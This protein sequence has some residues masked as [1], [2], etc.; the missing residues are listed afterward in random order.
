MSYFK[1]KSAAFYLMVAAAILGIV[2]ISFYRTAYGVE[3]HV[4]TFVWIG[5]ILTVAMAALAALPSRPRVLNL[6]ATVVAIVFG[7]A[8]IQSVTAQL[9]PLGFWIAGLYTYA[10]VKGY[11]FFAVLILIA[12]ILDLIASFMDLHK[13]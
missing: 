7:W 5:V 13:N 12:I 6:C 8:L 1:N 3:G 4:Q 11:I 2:G 9:D 10:Q